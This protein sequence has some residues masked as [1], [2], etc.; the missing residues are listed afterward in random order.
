MALSSP[1][2]WSPTPRIALN[3]LVGKPLE[4]GVGLGGSWLRSLGRKVTVLARAPRAP[5]TA[6]TP[7][8][9]ALEA[10]EPTSNP[11]PA[12]PAA[13]TIKVLIRT[14]PLKPY[15]MR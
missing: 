4:H 5:A 14:A 9:T 13:T 1:P 3:E 12:T 11:S 7:G 15:V 6:A 8:T 10:M 2:A